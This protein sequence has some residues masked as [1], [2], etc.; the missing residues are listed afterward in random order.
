[1]Y[2]TLAFSSQNLRSLGK[3]AS[4]VVLGITLITICA[5]L[6]VPTWPV[7]MTL[8][9]LGVMALALAMGPRL[10]TVTFFAYLATG[11]AGLP[12]F[13]GSPERGTGLL[14]MAGPTGGYLLGYLAASWITGW[15]ALGRRTAGRILAMLAGL[16]V[17]YAVGLPWLLMYL[18]VDQV[19]PLGFTPF[20]L[21]DLIN[22]AIVALG[23]HF[24]PARMRN[25]VS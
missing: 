13:S 12:V 6:R 10:A 24:V 15:M 8:H 16:S 18:P 19:I 1:M 14:Y 11:A 23:A 25:I 17:T 7:P 3:T 5:K 2:Q 20:F 9:T 21:G 22:I 4:A